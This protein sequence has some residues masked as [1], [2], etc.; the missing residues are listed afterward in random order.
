MRSTSLMSHSL[1]PV[2]RLRSPLLYLNLS[3]SQLPVI[4]SQQGL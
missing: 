2:L 3:V 1:C 4:V